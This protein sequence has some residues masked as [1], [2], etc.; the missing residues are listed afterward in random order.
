MG[1][2]YL[3]QQIIKNIKENAN[4]N[5]CTRIFRTN[6]DLLQYLNFCWRWNITSNGNQ[7]IAAN[8]DNN[9]N[10]SNSNNSNDSDIPDKTEI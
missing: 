2:I 5:I 9:D 6:R 7:T 1:K 8:D 4:C 10:T 3:H